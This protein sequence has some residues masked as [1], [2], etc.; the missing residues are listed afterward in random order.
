MAHLLCNISKQ[1][2]VISLH[3]NL[4]PAHPTGGGPGSEYGAEGGAGQ[5]TQRSA[6]PGAMESCFPVFLAGT[7]VSMESRLGT[8]SVV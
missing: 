7:P 8:T 5:G 2:S 1:K 4:Q 3:T 6:L